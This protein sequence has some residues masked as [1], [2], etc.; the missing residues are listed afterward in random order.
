MKVKAVLIKNQEKKV[1]NSTKDKRK[2]FEKIEKKPPKILV[3]LQ[4]Q[5]FPQ[6]TKIPN[7]SS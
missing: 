5:H 1:L 3:L 4:K 6:L 7:T 2:V